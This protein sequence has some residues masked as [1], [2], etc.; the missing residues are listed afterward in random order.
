MNWIIEPPVGF[1]FSLNV[2]G[3]EIAFKEVSGLS[4]EMGIEEVENGGENRFIHRIP[5]TAEYQNLVLQRAIVNSNSQFLNWCK[6]AFSSAFDQGITPKDINVT[7]HDSEGQ[8]LMR[9]N[10]FNAYPVKFEI[11]ELRSQQNE[12]PLETVELAYS[13]YDKQ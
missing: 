3:E 8:I 6:T 11:S 5:K 1:Y 12:V 13:Y 4:H 9:W 10:F 7:L 2:D